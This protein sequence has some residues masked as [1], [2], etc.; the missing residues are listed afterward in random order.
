[1]T[2]TRPILRYHGGKWKLAPW[3]IDNLP[4]HKSYVEPYGGAASVLLRKRRLPTEVYNDLDGQ[5]TGL[6][7]LL[8]DEIQADK[9]IKAVALTPFSRDEFD[10]SY[11]PTEDP[12]ESARRYIVRSF[13]GYGSKA[14]ISLTK[15]GF[16]CLRTGE[17]SPA[18]DWSRYPQALADVVQ[19]MRGVVIENKPALDVI[20]RFDREETLFYV[21]PPYV[22]STR[23]LVLGTYNFE[24]SDDDHQTLASALHDVKGMVAVSGYPSDLYLD[25]YSDWERL[26]R[27]AYADKAS[28]RTECLWISPAAAARRMPL[29]TA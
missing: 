26:E 4:P 16:R 28:P 20:R 5:L 9:L 8:Q 2:P 14:C 17:N 6:F 3:I 21:D 19:R 25:L 24:M 29:M 13:F 10:L 27:R 7:R 18:I 12:V 23:N 11:E 1:M 22:H 15:N